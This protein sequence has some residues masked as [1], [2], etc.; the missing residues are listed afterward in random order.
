MTD[1][2]IAPATDDSSIAN[3]LEETMFG[4]DESEIEEGDITESNDDELEIENAD[5]GEGEEEESNDEDEEPDSLAA[6]L[7][8][9][10]DQ[11]SEDEDGNVLVATKVNGETV[12]L[13]WKDVVVGYQ[14]QSSLTQNQQKLA[15]DRK[16]FDQMREQRSSEINA[17]LQASMYVLDNMEK[18]LLKEYN[19]V[20]WD[21]LR[22][23]NPA[24][25]TALRQDYSDKARE[26]E[27]TKTKAGEAAKQFMEKQQVD[28]A[29]T[30]QAYAV[31][32]KAELLIHIPE[33]TDAT[34]FS[35]AMTSAKKF[36]SEVY[37]ISD[38]ELNEILDNRLVRMILDAQ[39]FHKGKTQLK[40]KSGK[41]L[42]KFN[43]PG[44]RRSR[45]SSSVKIAKANKAALRKSGSTRD[46]ANAILDRM[47]RI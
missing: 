1:T 3:R 8:L 4:T 18:D 30:Q 36:A 27:E 44:A 39:K 45:Q 28:F 10:E 11:I 42:P 33:F 19:S 34:K 43:K 9:D 7:G 23:Q 47:Q 2:S 21:T 46:V 17:N 20:N 15:D 41:K 37:G 13:P 6:Y 32:E 38:D 22:S 16:E 25:Y 26:I 12:L 5:D 40:A 35:E 14:M 31:K 24:E 29:Q